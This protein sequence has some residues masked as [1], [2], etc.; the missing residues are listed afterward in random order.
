MKV[1]TKSSLLGVMLMALIIIS[2][3]NN[4]LSTKSSQSEVNSEISAIA[5]VRIEVE[6]TYV[7]LSL[8][9]LIDGADAI[10][11]G[12]V[13]AI[14]PTQWNQDNGEYWEET[15]RDTEGLETI[16]TALPIYRIEMNVIQ[17]L[18]D[19]IG[20]EEQVILTVVGMAEEMN[21]STG[22]LQVGD[23]V[24]AFAQQTEIA[25]H[26]GTKSIVQLMGVPTE[27]YLRKDVDGL[28][29]TAKVNEHPVSLENIISRIAQK[30]TI[31]S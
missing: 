10:F 8:D 27:S 30:R 24:V 12:H 26:N 6:T 13:V 22:G 15:L 5:D 14:S 16:R 25:W 17:P 20:L 29:H 1:I 18:V 7:N 21:E 19:G 3:C 4:T 9:Q 31:E 2:A 23:T 28:Y 11:L